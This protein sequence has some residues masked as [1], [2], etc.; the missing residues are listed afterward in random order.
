MY[1]FTKHEEKFVQH[2]VDILAIVCL[3][4]VEMC[5]KHSGMA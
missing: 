5:V 2:Y 3:F 1:L 4:A